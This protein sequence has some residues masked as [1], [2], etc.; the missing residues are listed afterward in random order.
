M[1]KR[2]PVTSIKRESFDGEVFNLELESQSQ[3]DDLYW[4]EH[5]TGV[6]THNCFPKDLNAMISLA[7]SINVDP[8]L[9]SAAWEKNLQVVAPEHRDWEKQVGRAVSKRNG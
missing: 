5:S 1:I 9:M 2:V 7:R 3:Q 6:F 4:C 8:S